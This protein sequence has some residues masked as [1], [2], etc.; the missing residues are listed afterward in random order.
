MPRLETLSVAADEVE[1]RTFNGREYLVAPV[2]AVNEGILK[3]EFL[4]N[5]EIRKVARAFNGTPLP[6]GHPVEDGQFVSAN[7]RDILENRVVGSFFEAQH[8]NRAL[9]GQIWIDVTKSNTLAGNRGEVFKQPIQKLEDGEEL[10]VSTAYWY[11]PVN[12]PG[13]F[14][15]ERYDVTQ[16]NLR[17][18]HLALLPHKKGEC[19]WEDGCGAPRVS[20]N[21]RDS[22]EDGDG[23]EAASMGAITS[24][25]FA[26]A[27]APEIPERGDSR[28][29]INMTTDPDPTDDPETVISRI[30]GLVGGTNGE[31]ED[32]DPDGE[33]GT[34]AGD[35]GCNDDGDTCSCGGDQHNDNTDDTNMSD[36]DLEALA[37]ET[38][39]DLETLEAMS[40]EELDAV[41]SDTGGDDDGTQK[42]S[43]G[44]S[45]DSDVLEAVN[46]IDEKIDSF[47]DRLE[48]LEQRDPVEAQKTAQLR[49]EIVAHSDVPESALPD[50]EEGLQALHAEVVPSGFAGRGGTSRAAQRGAVAGND[51]DDEEVEEYA[52]LAAQNN[53]ARFGDN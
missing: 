9:V 27:S 6:I 21:A 37:A 16:R 28:L 12:E 26:A 8:E 35:C 44:G 39:F 23:V 10:E 18:D 19:S 36:Y 51:A 25:D 41:A 38:A 20:P 43:N 33:F 29:F 47:E 48:A 15:G 32:D 4:P 40:D 3:G 46:S 14:N 1:R 30:R 45:D 11:D 24:P 22:A 52:D 2:V 17:P 31:Q 13:T 53:E 42:N 7:R 34:E 5:G 50:D 49:E